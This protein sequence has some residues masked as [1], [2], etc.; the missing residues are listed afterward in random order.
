[1]QINNNT[2]NF[3][4]VAD[5]TLQHMALQGHID[6]LSFMDIVTSFAQPMGLKLPEPPFPLFDLT[7]VDVRF[8]ATDTTIGNQTIAQGV[9]MI[10]DMN[11]LN[12]KANVH[13][14]VGGLLEGIKIFGSVD[15]INIANLLKIDGRNGSD[16]PEVDIELSL[17]RQNFLIQ[18]ELSLA[19]LYKTATSISITRAGIEFDFLE[20]MN[21][22][23]LLY[24]HVHGQSSGSLNNP[25][26]QISIDFEQHL[27]QYI[28]DRVNELFAIE[29]HQII[30][31][32]NAAQQQVNTLNQ[33][34]ADAQ[35]ELEEARNKVAQAEQS[36]N[37]GTKT[38][39]APAL[40][41]AQK[42]LQAVEQIANSILQLSDDAA[43]NILKAAQQ[44]SIGVLQGGT[45]VANQTLGQFEIN[46]IHYDGNLQDLSKGVL[47]NVLVEAQ[48]ITPIQFH[49]ML[50]SHNIPGSV[51]SLVTQISSALK[52]AVIDP[53]TPHI[54]QMKADQSAIQRAQQI[55]ATLK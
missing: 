31:S 23:T 36:L 33:V 48:I 25:Q 19:N 15:P 20:S 55:L 17:A 49:M 3:A 47:G 4:S 35:K 54:S 1:M 50:D 12:K 2:I 29:Q 43:Q 42:F 46:K 21:N 34:R 37:G 44:T 51:N 7:N 24:S 41:A 22:N 27:Q 8:A 30:A 38:L 53:F 39:A 18:G 45:W 32:I 9:T 14:N 40:Y 6:R 26:F 10:A 5:A 28:K 52:H 16:K 11:V 13:V